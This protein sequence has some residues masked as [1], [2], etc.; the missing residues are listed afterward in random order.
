[1][2]FY[3]EKR[4]S[5]F[6]NL[7]NSEELATEYLGTDYSGFTNKA[8]EK[9]RKA[10]MR[11]IDGIMLGIINGTNVSEAEFKKAERNILNFEADL[12]YLI[13]KEKITIEQAK[14]NGFSAN[15][16]DSLLS[17]YKYEINNQVIEYFKDEE[18]GKIFKKTEMGLW[19]AQPSSI[20]I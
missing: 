9:L 6:L 4:I 1:M 14:Q 5:H 8:L 13:L 16:L 19:L 7:W 17:A 12:A 3:T 10:K 18:D 2:G 15:Y 20:A 11:K